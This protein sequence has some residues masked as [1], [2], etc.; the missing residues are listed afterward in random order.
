MFC[1]NRP[2]LTCVQKTPRSDRNWTSS[3]A[4]VTEEEEAD[5]KTRWRMLETLHM[6]QVSLMLTPVFVYCLVCAVTG[7]PEDG[8]TPTSCKRGVAPP[9]GAERDRPGSPNGFPSRAGL[10]G[11]RTV[12]QIRRGG[13]SEPRLFL[14]VRV[15]TVP[16]R[17]PTGFH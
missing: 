4:D 14:N 15:N 3:S 16:A 2:A 6:L 11:T 7:R 9:V 17:P 1:R 12:G 5:D 13:L 8:P 10:L